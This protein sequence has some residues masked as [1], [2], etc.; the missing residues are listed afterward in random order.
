MPERIEAGLARTFC[1]R[2][3]LEL[4]S[5]HLLMG[6]DRISENARA[7]RVA[8]LAHAADAGDDGSR[9]LDQAWRVGEGAE[10][11]GKAGVTLPLDRAALS[12]ALGRDNVVHLA[13]TDTRAATRIAAMLHRLLLFQGQA[14]ATE[15]D[16]SRPAGGDSVQPGDDRPA[17]DGP[18]QEPHAATTN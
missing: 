2:L 6:T 14:E 3:G 9:K 1:D 15:H 10:G 5:G 16:A 12:V 4:K 7:G 13:L 17:R 11:T 8:W 18:C